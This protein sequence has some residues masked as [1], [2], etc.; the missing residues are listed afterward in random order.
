MQHLTAV[1]VDW[2]TSKSCTSGNC[3]EVAA[4]GDSIAIRDSKSP[5]S[6]VLLYIANEW[7]DFIAGAKNGDFDDLISSRP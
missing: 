2:R 3:V 7:R 1:N 6:A 5:S 4:L